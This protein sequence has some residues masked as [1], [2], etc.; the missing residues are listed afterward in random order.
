[1]VLHPLCTQ[2][3]RLF[4]RVEHSFEAAGGQRRIGSL[5]ILL[6]LGGLTGIELARWGLLP[7]AI[8]RLTPT[9]HLAAIEL[10]FTVLLVFE[11]ISL[12]LSLVYSVSISVGK[13]VE[14]LSLVMLR[15]IF[16]EVSTLHEPVVWDEVSG[17][18]LNIASLAL[19][20]LLIFVILSYYYR[21]VPEVLI[22]SDERDTAAFVVAKKLIALLMMAAFAAIFAWNW[23]H[24]LFHGAPNQT[25]ETLYTLL[26]FCDILIMLLS[27]RYGSSYRV[28]FRNSG[29]AVATLLIRV[30]LITPPPY[31]ALLGVGSALLVLAIRLAYNSYQPSRYQQ[32]REQ[33]RRPA[34]S[35]VAALKE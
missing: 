13:Q 14:I 26:I 5:L 9:N 31:S 35:P 7:S 32:Q 1:M 12:L 21:N 20:A 30:A 17:L 15:N 4:D 8:I 33:R 22:N 25:F 28:A 29:F 6:F 19:G 18:V 16:K 23:W 27:M 10:V 3:S 24:S 34:S 11:V 2:I